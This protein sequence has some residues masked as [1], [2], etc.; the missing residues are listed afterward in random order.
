LREH[1]PFD[2]FIVNDVF[3]HIY[4]TVGLLD[5]INELGSEKAQ[6]YFKVPNGLATRHVLMEGHKKKFGISLLPPD[7]WSEFVTAPF[8][9]Y[10]RRWA[11]FDS[12]FKSAGF[13]NIE[14][15]NKCHDEDIEKTR[16]FIVNDVNKIRR[17]LIPENFE[18]RKQLNFL[19]GVAREYYEEVADDLENMAWDD[20][21]W[22][23][24]VTFWEGML[25]R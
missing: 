22:K 8:H 9:I 15:F 11:Y 4:D 3:E 24:R 7:Y 12:L 6:V 19:K 17:H 10:Y 14:T 5:T 16:R 13:K 25:S 2:L 21:F 20:L 1:G 18:N 23:Y